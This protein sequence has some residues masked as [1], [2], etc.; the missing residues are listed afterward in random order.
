MKIRD[1]IK[2]AA[3]EKFSYYGFKNVTTDALAKDIGISKKTLYEYYPSKEALFEEVFGE[4]IDIENQQLKETIENLKELDNESFIDKIENS[5]SV[6]SKSKCNYSKDFFRD[7]KIYFPNLW[8]KV[9]NLREEEFKKSFNIIW[10]KGIEN[11]IF[12]K[13]INREIAYLVQSEAINNMLQPERLALISGSANEI[14]SQVFEILLAGCLT[15]DKSKEFVERRQ[16][17]K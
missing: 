17:T 2:N 3:K 7:L 6:N 12:R 16:K 14:I 10:D 9:I 8:Y 13:E 1:R 4:L 11:G 15:P 5:F